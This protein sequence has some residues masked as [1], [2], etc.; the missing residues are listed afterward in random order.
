[1][2]E[3]SETASDHGDPKRRFAIASH[4]IRLFEAQGL[5]ATT[6]EQIATAAGISSRTFFRYFA[7][8]EAAAFPDHRDRVAELRRRL[9]A[10]RGS[11]APVAAA[12]QVS[13][14][15]T[16]PYFEDGALY[17]PRYHLVQSVPTLRDYERLMDREYETALSDYIVAELGGHESSRIVARLLAAAIVAGVNFVLEV[18]AETEALDGE[19]LLERTF[20]HLRAAFGDGGRPSATGADAGDLVLVV[21]G[22]SALRDEIVRAIRGAEDAS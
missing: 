9:D 1:M 12:L 17:R 19:A 8:K 14:S 15:L 3:S 20:A 7:T 16:A 13:R 4:A 6:V 11:A 2:L 5:E 21:P 10:R 22:T 18:W